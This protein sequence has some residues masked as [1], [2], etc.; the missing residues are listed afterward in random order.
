MFFSGMRTELYPLTSIIYYI[1]LPSIKHW[2]GSTAR[3]N[4]YGMA[5]I[6]K[7]KALAAKGETRG[8]LFSKMLSEADGKDG[9]ESTLSE[10]EI[11]REA[12]NLI[13]AGS[14][15]TAVT[16]TYLV[17]AVLKNPSIKAR[18]IDEVNTLRANFS[19]SEAEALP[20]LSLVIK[21]TL[22]LYGAA[23]GSL[24]R[25]V[26][27]GGR[28]LGAYFVPEG[29]TVSTQAF[30]LHRDPLIYE[31]PL[32]FRPERWAQTTQSMKDA[33]MPWGGGSRGTSH[34]SPPFHQL[35]HVEK[36]ANTNDSS[37]RS[38]S[39]TPPCKHGA[40]PWRREILQGVSDSEDSD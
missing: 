26:P 1:P 37:I 40:Q 2:L 8:M 3:V 39:R 5:A 14:D 22:R 36:F 25:T 24:P 34:P 16:L 15:T 31:D 32:E 20:Y 28:T 27:A 6:Q 35:F 7:S 29:T 38:M 18:L 11:N 30:T 12:G 13:V 4:S 21:E 10:A 33:F 23:P 9:S 17:W 19:S